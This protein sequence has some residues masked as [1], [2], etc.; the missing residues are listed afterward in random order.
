MSRLPI[1][2][3]GHR[4][5]FVADHRLD[6][7]A[8]GDVTEQRQLDRAPA[9]AGRHQLDRAAAIPGALDEALF[10]EV[11]QVLVHRRE[12]RQAEAPADLLEARRV[13]V[14][15]DEV[16]E[17]VEDLALTLGQWLH[18]VRTIC[19]GKAKVKRSRAV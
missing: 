3:F 12:R 17:V 5:R 14:L 2:F 16:V 13:A 15:L 1:R 9:Q 18:G 19:K 6:R 11:G 4:D 8:G 10:L 7:R